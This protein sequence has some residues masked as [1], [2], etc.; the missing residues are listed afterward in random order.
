V[1]QTLSPNFSGR[2]RRE[3]RSI[4][5]GFSENWALER[6]ALSL[7]MVSSSFYS[8]SFSFF[9]FLPIDSFSFYFL[10]SLRS[11]LF[12]FHY[13]SV[14][15]FLMKYLV[16]LNSLVSVAETKN[17]LLLSFERKVRSSSVRAG[18]LYFPSFWAFGYLGY[19]DFEF[20]LLGFSSS[21]PVKVKRS[22]GISKSW[23]VGK[24]FRLRLILTFLPF[25]LIKKS[26]FSEFWASSLLIFWK[27]FSKYYAFLGMN[28]C[29]RI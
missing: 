17:I 21:S 9:L 27:S 29:S 5:L 11:S 8:Y 28:M 6:R 25:S 12:C 26:S 22:A 15:V 14:L 13:S 18:S 24:E 1:K 16:P 2:K 19:F 10:L 3:L 20:L 4:I 23:S 7:G